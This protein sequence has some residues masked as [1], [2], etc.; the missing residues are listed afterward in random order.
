[1]LLPTVPNLN[2]W[3]WPICASYSYQE[4]FF[5]MKFRELFKDLIPRHKLA[6]LHLI[7]QFCYHPSCQHPNLGTRCSR[8]PTKTLTALGKYCYP[9]HGNSHGKLHNVL[10]AHRQLRHHHY[11]IMKQIRQ[12]VKMPVGFTLISPHHSDPQVLTTRT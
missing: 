8:V 4:A 11:V 10:H 1:M 2:P 5:G 9:A 12:D 3:V 7:E 6:V